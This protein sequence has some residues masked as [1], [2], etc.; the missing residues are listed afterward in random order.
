MFFSNFVAKTKNKVNYL[1]IL[2]SEF[3]NTAV[4]E[5]GHALGLG[6]NPNSNA[7]MYPTLTASIFSKL[8]LKS[9]QAIY[10]KYFFLKIILSKIIRFAKKA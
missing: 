8:D 1:F 7:I 6:H 3:I 2:F 4:H 5:I 10:G 9:I